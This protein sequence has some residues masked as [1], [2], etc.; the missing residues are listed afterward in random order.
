MRASEEYICFICVSNSLYSLFAKRSYWSSG[1][2]NYKI[3]SKIPFTGNQ[4]ESKVCS[5]ER[6]KRTSYYIP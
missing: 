2:I 5:I 6:W 4:V 1:I 3:S